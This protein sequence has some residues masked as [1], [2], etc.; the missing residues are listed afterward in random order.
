VPCQVAWDAG[1]KEWKWDLPSWFYK[2]GYYTIAEFL[3]QW[4]EKVSVG[5]CVVVRIV[6]T[7]ATR[8]TFLSLPLRGVLNT[9]VEI[10]R[11]RG[12]FVEANRVS[13]GARGVGILRN[14]VSVNSVPSFENREPYPTKQYRRASLHADLRG[15]CRMCGARC[16][17]CMKVRISINFFLYSLYGAGISRATESTRENRPTEADPTKLRR[18]RNSPHRPF[19]TR[20]RADSSSFGMA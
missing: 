17:F 3:A 4:L 16:V 9:C 13:S 7:R 15:F 20:A 10:S 5:I 8:A 14:P 11:V 12:C 6:G 2:K 1:A 18:T 19:W